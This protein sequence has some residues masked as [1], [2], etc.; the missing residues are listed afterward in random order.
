MERERAEGLRE[1]AGLLR[2]I[3][4]G[5][6]AGTIPVGGRRIPCR[7]DLVATI[8]APSG[9]DARVLAVSLQL[10]GRRDMTRPL[11]LE[12]ELAHPGG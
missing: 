1:V 8:E 2:R 11:M 4:D 3:A 5:I 12:E 7:Q 10:T 6:E 9:G